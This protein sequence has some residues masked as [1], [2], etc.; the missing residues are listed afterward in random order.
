MGTAR[1]DAETLLPNMWRATITRSLR[2]A[3]NAANSNKQWNEFTRNTNPHIPSCKTPPTVQWGESASWNPQCGWCVAF[4]FASDSDGMVGG[5]G[6]TRPVH[7]F[8]SWACVPPV[9]LRS[10]AAG[11]LMLALGFLIFPM[12]FLLLASW[13]NFFFGFL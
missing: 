6:S 7:E 13:D 11:L 10:P 1:V 4:G 8:P 2:Y 9:H 3:R 12:G 5:T